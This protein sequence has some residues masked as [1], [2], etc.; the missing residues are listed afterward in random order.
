VSCSGTRTFGAHLGRDEHGALDCQRVWLKGFGCDDCASNREN[1]ENHERREGAK[2][3]FK[4]A[5]ESRSGEVRH[6]GKV[7]K[8]G[9][10]AETNPVHVIIH[11]DW[12]FVLHT[13][14][15]LASEKL[16]AGALP[17]ARQVWSP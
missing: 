5:V 9:M 11:A 14:D 4:M 13:D 15:K 12:C 3:T 16:E 10:L 17:G 6:S 1:Q 8:S 2:N 7:G